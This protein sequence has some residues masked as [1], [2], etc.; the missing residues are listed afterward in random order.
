MLHG[1]SISWSLLLC[2][3]GLVSVAQC[4]VTYV[5]TRT[6]DDHDITVVRMTVTPA[7]EPVPLFDHR[8]V[9]RDIE[10]KS[11][12]AAPFYYR[13]LL[14]L[15]R[16][17]EA[18]RKKYDEEE[19]L[20]KW[21]STGSEAVPV[22]QLPLAKVRDALNIASGDTWNELVEATHRRHCDFELGLPEIRGIQLVYTRLEEFQRSRELTRI[23]Q[24]RARLAIAERRY[25]DAV[26]TMRISYRLARDFGSVPF[27]VSGLIG[28]AEA[29]VTN[30]TVVELIAAPQ[31]PNLYWAL[32]EL[33]DPLISMRD[34]ARFELDF[35]PR[36]FP[37]VH[38]AETTDRS[39]QEW[40]RQFAQ[41]F[42]DLHKA[43]GGDGLFGTSPAFDSDVSAGFVATAA[44]LLGYSHAKQSLIAAGLDGKRV[45]E[46][47]VGQVM[48][49][50]TERTY[51][52][53]AND[54]EKLWYMPFW[55]MRQYVDTLEKQITGA[56]VAGGGN[57]R[58]VVPIVSLLLPAMEAARSAQGR[59]ERDIAALR[60][61]E[62]LR[63]Y[64]AAHDA[65]LPASLDDIEQVPVPTNPATGKP[66]RYRL[67][68]D[69]AIL[70]LPDSEGF[71]GYNR[72]FEIQIAKN[73]E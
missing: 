17:M 10:L 16:R 50:Y 6:T 20:G 18:V 58:E 44:A 70:E 59:L 45:E 24:L 61:I 14:D 31:S 41:L 71:P 5:E 28:I 33:P 36:M 32:S 11:G 64:A 73:S 22:D 65:R 27:I 7:A 67:E 38:Q 1:T 62:A 9:A 68:G 12:N 40:N 42:R 19:E 49:I 72:R 66:F 63:I 25:D 48:A 3:A 2:T 29:S 23:L 53:F 52:R 13:A 56:K 4:E 55:E 15:P 43:G 21:Y 39:P 26:E 37:V 8:F 54:W 35:V 69:T 47:A 34:A 60:V 46:M 51:K 57:E 30:G